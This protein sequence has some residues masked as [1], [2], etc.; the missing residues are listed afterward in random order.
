MQT[1]I[2][3]PKFDVEKLGEAAGKVVNI[4]AEAYTEVDKSRVSPRFIKAMIEK[5]T[6]RF[7]GRVDVVPRLYLREFVDVLDKCAMY[8]NYQPMEKYVFFPENGATFLKEEEKV[9]MEVAW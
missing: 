3:L 5:V 1:Q 6:N 2:V 4:Y 7:G 8:P 9:V